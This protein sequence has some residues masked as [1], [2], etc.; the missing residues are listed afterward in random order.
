MTK[1]WHSKRG[2]FVQ[3]YDTD[4]LDAAVLLMPLGARP[5]SSRPPAGPR[6]RR[7]SARRRTRPPRGLPACARGGRSDSG[8]G[9]RPPAPPTP[10]SARAEVSAPGSPTPKTSSATW[11]TSARVPC[12]A[13]VEL[14]GEVAQVGRE[15]QRVGA[16]LGQ[17]RLAGELAGRLERDART[18]LERA[19]R[20]GAR[21]RKRAAPT[22]PHDGES[23]RPIGRKS[24][25][26]GLRRAH[27][28]SGSA[29][30]DENGS[31]SALSALLAPTPGFD[32]RRGRA[33]ERP[34]ETL[35]RPLRPPGS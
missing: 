13:R 34:A 11:V 16:G 12:V 7:R 26:E 25:L 3:H 29:R 19:A 23:P 1:G 32:R 9:R 30:P 10:R 22:R 24:P 27:S 4:V 31:L 20:H 17:E 8:G 18:G 35:R 33:A 28:A 21:H 5:E 14:D 6:R 15:R 2:A